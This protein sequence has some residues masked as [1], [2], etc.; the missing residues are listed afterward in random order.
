MT[1]HTDIASMLLARAGDT[2]PGLRTRDQTWTW[3]E[4]VSCSAARAALAGSAVRQRTSAIFLKLER[5]VFQ[6]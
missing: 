2:H 3:D 6:A 5:R 4:V 1:S